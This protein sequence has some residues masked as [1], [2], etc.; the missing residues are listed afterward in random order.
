MKRTPTPVAGA[1]ARV[2][3]KLVALGI[4]AFGGL[5]ATACQTDQ[6]E[7]HAGAL[8]ADSHTVVVSP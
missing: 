5:F 2:H 1:P 6:N 4:V 8:I 7:A 3:W